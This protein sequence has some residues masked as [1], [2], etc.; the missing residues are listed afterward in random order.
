MQKATPNQR[1]NSQMLPFLD[2]YLH[3]KNLRYQ[4]F[5]SKD[6]V[7]QRILQSDWTTSTSGNT[8]PKMTLKMLSFF[9]DS[10]HAKN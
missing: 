10:F 7:D 3:A 1:W 2:A 5:L 6:T 4:L 8:Q 9:D